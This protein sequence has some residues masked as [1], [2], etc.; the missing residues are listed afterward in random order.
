M[1]KYFKEKR[2]RYRQIAIVVLLL[3]IGSVIPL[4]Y[5]GRFAH[6][7]AD[8][9]TYGYLAHGFWTTTGSVWEALKWA[10]NQVKATY[11]T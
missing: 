9:F 4:L 5:I 8:D 3:L 10:V 6:P 11:D 7:C 2:Y 1:I